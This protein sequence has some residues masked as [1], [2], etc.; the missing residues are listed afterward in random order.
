MGRRNLKIDVYIEKAAPFAQP[1]LNHLREVV[2]LACLDVVETVKWGFPHFEFKGILCSM[3]AFKQ[4]CTFG[5][6]KGSI[7]SD[8]KNVMTRNAMGQFDRITSLSDLPSDK[9][10]IAYIKEAIKLNDDNVK[11]PQ[12]SK[13]KNEKALTIPS[14]FLKEIKK[15]KASMKT[16]GGFSNSNK[17]EYI[18]WVEEAKTDATREKRMQTAIEWIA[19][20]KIRNWKYV[21][22]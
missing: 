4:H 12:R 22:K 11:L 17:K 15:N 21:R 8:S 19:E 10:L 9:I 1:I 16:F 5:F 6:W 18:E 14:Y 2:H 7:M 20:G 13:T 3:A